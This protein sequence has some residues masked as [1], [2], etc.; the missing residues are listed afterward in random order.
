MANSPTTEQAPNSPAVVPPSIQG[1]LSFSTPT[2]DFVAFVRSRENEYKGRDGRGKEQHYVPLTEL[3]TYWTIPK[4]RE[5][6]ESYSEAFP[7]RHR[8]IKDRYLRVFSTLV[9]IGKL[10]YLPAF[11]RMGLGDQRFPDTTLPNDWEQSPSHRSMFDDFKSHQWTFFPVILDRD[12][13]DDTWLPPER[14]LPLRV[15]AKIREQLYS[16]RAT[17]TKVQFHPS[18]NSLVK[19]SWRRRSIPGSFMDLCAVPDFI[20]LQRVT[21]HTRRTHPTY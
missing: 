3:Y 4:I 14:I 6:C 2:D 19:V 7:T 20:F 13:L 17:I 18:C 11:Q 12:S 1:R 5:A 21:A 16:D 10:S 15:Q 9:F 8:L